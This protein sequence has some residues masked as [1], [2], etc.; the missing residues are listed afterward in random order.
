MSPKTAVV[1]GATS[2]LG[3]LTAHRLVQSGMNVVLVGRDAARLATVTAELRGFA[4]Y[5]ADLS[6]RSQVRDLAAALAADGIRA[7]V[8]VNNAGAAFPATR[9]P[10]TAWNAPTPSTT[11]RRSC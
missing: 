5:T 9:K 11:T 7:D 1:T 4:S 3:L 8:L 6:Q 10:R 2:G